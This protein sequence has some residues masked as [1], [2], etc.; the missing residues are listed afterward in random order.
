MTAIFIFFLVCSDHFYGSDC[1]TPCGHCKNNDVCDNVTGLCLNGC[2]NHWNGNK[3]DS[4]F[5]EKNY[6]VKTIQ[7]SSINKTPFKLFTYWL[8]RRQQAYCLPRPQLFFTGKT[9]GESYRRV[10]QATKYLNYMKNSLYFKK[11]NNLLENA[12]ARKTKTFV[13][14]I[15][16]QSRSKIV[17]ILIACGR[18]RQQSVNQQ[19][20][21]QKS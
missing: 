19:S 3:C 12:V 15:I 13:K 16:R 21:G 8:R 17:Q 4:K 14:F 18:L 11:N 5:K 9:E 20:F 6:I 10:L 7:I 2:H 1:N